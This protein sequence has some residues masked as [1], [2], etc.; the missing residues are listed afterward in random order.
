M[1]YE[2][3]RQL[4]EAGLKQIRAIIDIAKEIDVTDNQ[5]FLNFLDELNSMSVEY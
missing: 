3:L 4:Y 1:T 5:D 2:L